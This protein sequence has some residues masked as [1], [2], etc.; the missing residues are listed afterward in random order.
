[1]MKKIQGRH[2]PSMPIVRGADGSE[3]VFLFTHLFKFHSMLLRL[4]SVLIGLSVMT[5]SAD[6]VAETLSAATE[7]DTLTIVERI[8]IP[9]SGITVIA[10]EALLRRALPVE[11]SEE[12]AEEP[13]TTSEDNEELPQ[14]AAAR[15]K[16][17]KAVGYRVQVYADNNVRSAKVE[18]RQRER[19]VGQAFPELSTYVA[20]ASPYWRLRVGDFKSQYEAEKAAAEIRKA[21]PGY[22]REVRVVRDRVNIR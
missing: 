14:E 11:E 1:M 2:S 4:K 6:C 18:A 12:Q 17:G 16:P 3:L 13:A 19:A 22:A 20:Y 21:F 10:P 7:P 5:A 8:Q 15:T 9:G